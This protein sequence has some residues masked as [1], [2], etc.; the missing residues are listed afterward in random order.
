MNRGNVFTKLPLPSNIDIKG[1]GI[2][3]LWVTTVGSCL[4]RLIGLNDNE[5]VKFSLAKSA[6]TN[7]LREIELNGFTRIKPFREYRLLTLGILRK[8]SL[9]SSAQYSQESADDSITLF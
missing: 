7:T 5:F 1:T 6:T 9:V 3:Q 8:I 4:G 2:L